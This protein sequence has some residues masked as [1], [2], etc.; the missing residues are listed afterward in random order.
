MVTQ[1][2]PNEIAA[3]ERVN[4]DYGDPELGD[5]YF[6][7]YNFPDQLRLR[8]TMPEIRTAMYR[9]EAAMRD[10]FPPIQAEREL[11]NSAM[12]AEMRAALIV[13]P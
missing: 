2:S 9:F 8:C 1:L 7:A 4:A 10:L 13:E 6:V 3:M 5:V 12:Y 11:A